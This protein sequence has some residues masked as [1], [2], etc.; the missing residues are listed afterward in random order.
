MALNKQTVEQI[1]DLARLALTEEQIS[2]YQQQLSAILTY[3]EHL[4]DLDLADVPPTTHAVPLH[5]VLRAD[6]V[7]G[8][9]TIAQ[10]LQNAP[11]QAADQFVIQAVLEA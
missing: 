5:N 6:A 11:Q 1:A 10:V 9:L 2:L 8:S 4:N 3:A 7:E